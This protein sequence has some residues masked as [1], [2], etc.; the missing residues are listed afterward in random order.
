MPIAGRGVCRFDLVAQRSNLSAPRSRPLEAGVGR[1]APVACRCADGARETSIAHLAVGKSL[2]RWQRDRVLTTSS[3]IEDGSR[4][5]IEAPLA[6]VHRINAL[7]VS[8]REKR[9]DIN[10]GLARGLGAT[11]IRIRIPGPRLTNKK[12]YPRGPLLVPTLEECRRLHLYLDSIR[13]LKVVGGPFITD[14]L[15]TNT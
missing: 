11:P 2:E 15:S 1:L 5:N 13:R 3:P 7:L 12:R 4:K 9:E 8:M 6:D 10:I 14:T